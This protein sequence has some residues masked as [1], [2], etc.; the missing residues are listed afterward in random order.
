VPLFRD[1][2][3]K[4]KKTEDGDLK[5]SFAPENITAVY[6]IFSLCMAMVQRRFLVF[7][8]PFIAIFV[9]RGLLDTF[10]VMKKR[11]LFGMRSTALVI[12]VLVAVSFALYPS[13]RH[14]LT[15]KP[16]DRKDISII[17][18]A[19]FLSDYSKEKNLDP[20]KSAVLVNWGYGHVFEFEA[21]LP[22][23]CDN[24]F[25]P[26]ENDSAFMDCLR[27]YYSP[28]A[29]KTIR[30]L[31]DK[32]VRFIILFPP[33]PYQVKLE[34]ETLDIDPDYFVT[35]N[36]KFTVYFS[37]T[38]MIKLAANAGLIQDLPSGEMRSIRLIHTEEN[39][40]LFEITGSG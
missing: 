24:F 10:E 17:K 36:E 40:L 31:F 2:F 29:D 27:Y 7:A 35:M 16:L 34:A 37:E 4:R 11:F 39:I 3:W 15:F 18:T 38:F 13:I 14:D 30:E 23:V 25:G 33:D 32:G 22:S 21:G 1:D 8:S 28:D 9:A 12:S 26:P 5:T 6:F 19:R 20:A